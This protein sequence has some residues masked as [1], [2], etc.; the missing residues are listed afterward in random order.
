MSSRALLITAFFGAVF[1]VSTL[2]EP[3]ISAYSDEKPSQ[4]RAVNTSSPLVEDRS[5]K[6]ANQA[7]ISEAIHQCPGV[8]SKVLAAENP[9]I[10]AELQRM[11]ALC[12]IDVALAK[13]KQAAASTSASN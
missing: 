12:T 7:E 13:Q 5:A 10:N 6:F 8:K 3:I 1:I 11:I 2:Y 9:I 4:A